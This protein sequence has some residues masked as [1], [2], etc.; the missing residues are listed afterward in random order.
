MLKLNAAIDK[1]LQMPDVRKRL[2]SEGAE[3][4]GGSPELFADYIKQQKQEMGEIVSKAGL[5]LN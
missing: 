3:I 2:D 1:V 5:S 4:V